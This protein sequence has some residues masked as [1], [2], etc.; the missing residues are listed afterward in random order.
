L[1]RHAAG[2]GGRRRL[3]RRTYYAR[4][5]P[6]IIVAATNTKETERKQAKKMRAGVTLREQAQFAE[7]LSSRAA[8]P[9]IGFREHL[10]KLGGAIEE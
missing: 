8:N 5:E 9:S 10:R 3:R 6:E 1:D 2:C 4:R 7:Y